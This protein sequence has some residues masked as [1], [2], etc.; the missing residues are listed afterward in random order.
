[1]TKKKYQKAT[2]KVVNVEC[3]QHL[4]AGSAGGGVSILNGAAGG[5]WRELE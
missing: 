5:Q 3:E 1:M 4:L 2:M